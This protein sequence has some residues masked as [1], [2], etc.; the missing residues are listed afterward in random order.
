M[1]QLLTKP[2]NLPD[3]PGVYF[4]KDTAG[5]ILYI[6]KA[7]NLRARI[8]QYFGKSDNRPQ[9][10]FLMA[11]AAKL[12][13]TIVNT[14]LES[15]YLERN[16]IQQHRPRYNIELKDDKNFAFITIDYAAEIP[17]IGYARKFEPGKKNVAYF[18]PY[19]AAGKIR[20]TLNTI[21]KI[22]TYCAAQKI[23]GKP[24]FYYHLHRCPG[25]CVGKITP[26]EYRLHMQR[27]EKFL[28]GKTG[29]VLTQLKTE[30]RR[31]A[32]AKKFEVAARFRD[33]ARSLELVLQKQNIILTKPSNWDVVSVVQEGFFDSVN[34]FKIRNGRMFDKE[35][36]VYESKTGGE[37]NK[38][39]LASVLQR[40]LED[41]YLSASDLPKQ[42]FLN[43]KI[44]NPGLIYQL[45]K[46]RFGK[47]VKIGA[48]LRGRAKNLLRLGETNAREFLDKWL[49]GRAGNLDKIQQALEQL[50]T[51]LSLPGLPKLIECYDI[52][53]IQGTNA[54]GSMV[55]FKDGLPARQLYRK[56]KIQTKQTPD[57]FAMLGEMLGR[58]LERLKHPDA[59]WPKPDLIVIDGSK[60]QLSAAVEALRAKQAAIPLIGLA[61]RIEEIFLPG[62]AS[63]LLLAHDQPGLQ[64]LQRIRDEAH[65]YG[66]TYHRQLRSKQAVRSV[67]DEIP[68][69]GP[70]T[71]KLLK[72][73]FGTVTQIKQAS[74]EELAKAVGTKLAQTLKARL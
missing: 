37:Q 73:K 30:M 31:A 5:R 12:D 29:Q 67:L 64:L 18:G 19:T 34:L 65:R 50:K 23:T 40:F 3:K 27:I 36:F 1:N 33:Q 7:K 44:A 14:E 6:G 69:V 71:K 41:Y 11:E 24:C 17:Q 63:P 26:V 13:Y 74:L 46:S 45:F 56:F 25:V 60:G 20:N 4:F 66:I 35:N 51:E 58:R 9:I 72:Q 48:A 59:K 68:G 49:T 32:Q 8:A 70:K 22:F 53:N 42:I 54:V 15:L 62:S 2:K 47:S 38:E 43:G 39:Y 57:D 21:R 61:K 10:P 16:L 28:S 52:S 55:V